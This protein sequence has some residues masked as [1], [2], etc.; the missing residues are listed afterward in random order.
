MA[1][2]PSL[3]RLDQVANACD[4]SKKQDQHEAVL[5]ILGL[6][7]ARRRMRPFQSANP[8]AS[9]PNAPARCLCRQVRPVPAENL[10]P[11]VNGVPLG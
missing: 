1:K 10:I 3:E 6:S 2:T 8:S 4:L 5:R 9:S 7:A 11:T